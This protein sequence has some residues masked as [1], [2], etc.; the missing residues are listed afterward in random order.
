MATHRG[1]PGGVRQ[2]VAVAGWLLLSV[3]NW[4]G[5]EPL[6]RSR[7]DIVP[8]Y[9][10]VADAQGRLVPDL[11]QDDFDVF[12]NGKAVEIAVF[13]ND[14]QPITVVA[15]LDMSGSRTG[16]FLRV[17]AGM[18]EFV[19]ALLPGDRVRI[20]TYGHEI[21]LSPLL[22]GSQSDLMRVLD[23]ELW[24]GGGTPTWNAVDAA[25]TSLAGERGRRVVLVLTDNGESDTLPGRRA[26]YTDVY[27]RAT[28]ESYLVYAISLP[29][30]VKAHGIVSKLR[31]A[32]IELAHDTG[33]GYIDLGP[34]DPLAP[35]FRRVAEE[36]RHQYLIGFRPAI[37]DGKEHKLEVTL[38]RRGLTARARRNYVAVPLQ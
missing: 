33:G 30:L 19:R 6:F 34:G 21:S 27:R 31:S 38:K 24:P 3:G 12:D 8:I 7:I 20:G 32:M 26:G 18:Q 5:Q 1:R 2:S 10:T 15:M 25:L 17:R 4:P 29:L 11:V 36:L 28:R 22:T 13:S 23:E 16:T 37:W 35:T 14:P 9:T